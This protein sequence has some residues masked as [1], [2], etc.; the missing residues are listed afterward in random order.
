MNIYKNQY[1]MLLCLSPLAAWG[2]LMLGEM[3]DWIWLAGL[4]LLSGLSIYLYKTLLLKENTG[5]W[6]R[7][8]LYFGLFYGQ[9]TV[10]YSTTYFLIKTRK[11]F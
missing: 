8:A 9:L 7:L 5:K 11:N 10:L 2:T 1:V 6:S 3:G 4:F